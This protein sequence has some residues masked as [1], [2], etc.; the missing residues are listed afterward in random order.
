MLSGKGAREA[1]RA[2]HDAEAHCD[3]RI[4]H[5]PGPCRGTIAC[6]SSRGPSW[7]TE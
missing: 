6:R 4:D 5:R 3:W 1:R 7:S 2:A